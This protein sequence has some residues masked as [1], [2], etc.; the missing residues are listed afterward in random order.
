MSRNENLQFIFLKENNIESARGMAHRTDCRNSSR[1][2][3]FDSIPGQDMI[4][5]WWKAHLRAFPVP[6]RPA[7]F[8]PH[9]LEI[10]VPVKSWDFLRKEK[11]GNL[12]IR[13]RHGVPLYEVA[14]VTLAHLA[15]TV[16]IAVISVV[17]YIV[18]L[19][20]LLYTI[21][22]PNSKTTSRIR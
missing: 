8:P 22:T 11:K 14:E 15:V 18:F 2:E 1:F 12:F 4:L 21:L 13:T 17:T 20:F 7:L 3:N 10:P 9:A 6:V 5:I 16:T 19:P